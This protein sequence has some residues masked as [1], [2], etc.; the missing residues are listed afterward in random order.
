M[1][2]RIPLPGKAVW[3]GA[4]SRHDLRSAG[5]PG[6]PE[7]AGFADEVGEFGYVHSLETGSTVDGP[8]VR[9]TLFLAGCLLRCQYCHNPDTWHLKDGTRVS[10]DAAIARL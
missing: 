2:P 1:S 7:T 3:D 4:T 8:G 10:A 6:A 9:A 5:S